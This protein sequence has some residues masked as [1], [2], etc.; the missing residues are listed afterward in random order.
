VTEKQQSP[1]AADSA[2]PLN[3]PLLGAAFLCERVLQERD[4]V[5]SA[6]RLVDTWTVESMPPP[7]VVAGIRCWA[8]VMFKS[9][10]ARGRYNVSFEI[11]KPSGESKE[12]G[13]PQTIDLKGGEH[14]AS[15]IIEIQMPAN[16][17]GLF[18]IDVLLDG[19]RITSMPLK[20]RRT[21]APE[22]PTSLSPAPT[23]G[24]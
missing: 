5:V 24:S 19:E 1:N 21:E 22:R 14:G 8:F 11:R 6:M 10:D 2:P 20:L 7:G 15:L 23:P 4:D 3:K 18:W 12:F 13:T 9:G 17:M 16:E